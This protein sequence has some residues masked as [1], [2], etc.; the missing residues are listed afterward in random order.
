MFRVSL[1]FERLGG[2]SAVDVDQNGDSFD[3]ARE[4]RETRLRVDDLLADGAIEE[5][6][7]YMEERRRLFVENGFFIRK[8]NQAYFAIT[9]TY[10]EQ[11]QSSSPI[12]DQMREV[13]SLVPDIKTFISTVSAVSTPQEFV[14]ALEQ[15]RAGDPR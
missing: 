2:A 10:A 12:G 11:P 14:D 5:A 13:R 3:F 6:E 4:M 15:L 7:A 9:G 1:A 8:L